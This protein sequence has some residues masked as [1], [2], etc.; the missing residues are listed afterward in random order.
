MRVRAQF[1]LPNVR[2]NPIGWVGAN[3]ATAM[4]WATLYASLAIYTLSS[5]EVSTGDIF[6][7]KI[8]PKRKDQNPQRRQRT[9]RSVYP[10]G[11]TLA[12]VACLFPVRFPFTRA[13]NPC[14]RQWYPSVPLI[15]GGYHTQQLSA[16]FTQTQHSYLQK[17]TLNSSHIFLA[18]PWG[19]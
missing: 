16:L 12:A 10:K 6:P 18:I 7:D 2:P 15:D 5:R 17:M 11:K 19:D 9:Q 3:S 1:L 13:C 4:S 8:K 14:N